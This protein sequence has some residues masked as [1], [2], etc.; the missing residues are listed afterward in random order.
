MSISPKLRAKRKQIVFS[1]F[2]GMCSYCGCDINIENFH[3]DH[4][5]PKRRNLKGEL[6]IHSMDYGKQKGSDKFEN[7]MPSCVSC[8]SSKH[9]HTIEE[10]R[11]S[12]S[13]RLQNLYKDVPEYRTALRFGM[14]KEV[15]KDIKFY[16][17]TVNNG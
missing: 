17:E 3:I 1:K 2:G 13:K 16:F 7:L 14:I 4:F 10:W 15:K 9:S 5:I 6:A 8:N 12:L 11:E